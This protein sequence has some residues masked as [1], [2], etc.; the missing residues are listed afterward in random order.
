MKVVVFAGPDK[1]FGS[2]DHV[3]CMR[4]PA[5]G[6]PVSFS[7]AGCSS[8]PTRQESI[9]AF[10]GAR[11]IGG[12][13]RAVRAAAGQ[14][15]TGDRLA[16]TNAPGHNCGGGS[17]QAMLQ[18]HQ[19]EEIKKN[20]MLAFEDTLDRI[21]G[22]N[23][24]LSRLEEDI[25]VRTLAMMTCGFF[26]MAAHELSELLPSTAKLDAG[27]EM[28]RPHRRLSLTTAKLREGLENLRALD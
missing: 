3:N 21:E 13:Y 8:L 14:V 23:R 9:P 16:V 7:R 28:S 12:A 10:P 25:L 22:Y 20:V 17:G 27:R 26:I 18:P 6:K 19:K 1:K 24:P 2:I 5:R 11:P 15:L 4:Q